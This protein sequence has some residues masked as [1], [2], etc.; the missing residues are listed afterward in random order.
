MP[1]L[2]FRGHVGVSQVL[3]RLSHGTYCACMDGGCKL[4]CFVALVPKHLSPFYFCQPCSISGQS[5]LGSFFANQDQAAYNLSPDL[6]PISTHQ[7]RPAHPCTAQTAWYVLF[8]TCFQLY[9][10]GQVITAWGLGSFILAKSSTKS[11]QDPVFSCFADICADFT[12]YRLVKIW[13]ER[14]LR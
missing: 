3:V 6:R 12:T 5:W 4:C 1:R 14:F 9:T 11:T 2:R 10:P 13:S 7:H 8:W